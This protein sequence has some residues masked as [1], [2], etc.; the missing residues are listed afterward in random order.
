[1]LRLVAGRG[2][3]GR[4][5]GAAKAATSQTRQPAVRYVRSGRSAVARWRA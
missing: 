4:L 3:V 2:V 5:G 1:M